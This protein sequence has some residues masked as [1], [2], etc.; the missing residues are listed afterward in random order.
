[1]AFDRFAPTR[2]TDQFYH[3]PDPMDP[4]QNAPLPY[5]P[6]TENRSPM[7]DPNAAIKQLIIDLLQ[8]AP[9]PP[10]KVGVGRRIIGSIGDALL[11]S[12]Q[13]RAGGVASGAGPFA[14]SMRERQSRYDESVSKTNEYNR[15]TSRN[16]R[17]GAAE[18]ERRQR[19]ALELETLRGKNA[20]ERKGTDSPWQFR[21]I[22][23][24]DESGR[25]RNM[26]I[27]V[28]KDTQEVV[29]AKG[30]AESSRPN[31]QA[32]LPG[33]PGVS[34]P[35]TVDR[36][37][38]PA[39]EIPGATTPP[40]PPSVGTDA[41]RNTTTL[42]GLDLLGEAYNTIRK[43]TAGEGTI[44]DKGKQYVGNM[45]G[46]SRVGGMFEFSQ[47]YAAYISSKRQ[48]LNSYIKSVT[49]AQFSVAELERYDTQ[50]PEP[51]DPPELAKQKLDNLAKRAV[52][53]MEAKKRLYP[54]ARFDEE[55]KPMWDNPVAAQASPNA[56]MAVGSASGKTLPASAFNQLPPDRR[57][58]EK[59]RFRANG[60]TITEG[61]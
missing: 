1:M 40:P 3:T 12:S 13:V 50:Y 48:S 61:Q 15:E 6:G 41:A 55:G 46:E 23:T 19:A 39:K 53:D 29:E 22:I 60:G 16:V 17:I 38:G 24:T 32:I 57:E 8:P 30:S 51:W 14:A 7:D 4:S 5:A 52:D 2:Q 42:S 49:G 37:G 25:P 54:G 18:D 59:A 33:V 10:K 36:Y 35:M 21:N 44:V 20:L 28:N 26:G 9:T 27:W 34:P 11:A 31:P 47:P 43:N 45:L 56:S 58:A